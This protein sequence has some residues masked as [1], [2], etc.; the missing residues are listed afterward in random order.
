MFIGLR[1]DTALMLNKKKAVEFG[2]FKLK[3]HEKNPSAPLSPF[4]INMRNK[5]NPTKAG[6]LEAED[7]E[8]IARC[9]LQVIKESDFEFDAIAGIPRAADPIVNALE[10]LMDYLPGMDQ[11]DF[12][13]IRLAKEEKD[14]KRRIV[15]MPGFEYR[16][17]ERV[18]LI[19]DLVTKADTKI[20]AI[21]AVESQG[22]VVAGLVVLVDRLQGGSKEIE[23]AG[24]KMKSAFTIRELLDFY[25]MEKCIDTGKWQEAIKYIETV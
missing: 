9:L 14:G 16:K 25:V 23:N 3:L 5:D 12:R 6:P 13:I 17:G 10:K 24:Y 8:L 11:G 19:D 7:Y 15:P 18:L 21:K 4:Y 1:R 20:E 22:A 2:A